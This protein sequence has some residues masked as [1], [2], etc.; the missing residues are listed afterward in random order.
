MKTF[1]L[2]EM[3]KNKT[4]EKT[5]DRK[6]KE[7]KPRTKRA[8]VPVIAVLLIAAL[9]TI[10]VKHS[11]KEIYDYAPGTGTIYEITVARKDRTLTVTE[12][13]P[14]KIEEKDAVNNGYEG[15]TENTNTTVLTAEEYRLF[16][17]VLEKDRNTACSAL[18]NIA[19][20]DKKAGKVDGKDITSREFGMMLLKDAT[21]GDE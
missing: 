2:K 14:Y 4:P 5:K 16:K 10:I 20:D 21:E 19:L 1:D 7:K 17:D 13:I 8:A 11:G 9:I 15:T 18:V 3:E 6:V 12:R